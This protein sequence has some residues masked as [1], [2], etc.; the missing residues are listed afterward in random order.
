[1]IGAGAFGTVYSAT[2]ESGTEG[3]QKSALKFLPTGTCTP[4]QLGH[5]RDLAEREVALLKRVRA[6]RL[7][8]MHATMT[9]DDPER[10]ELDGA[11]VLVLERAEESLEA[12][13]ERG[14]LGREGAALL[15]QIC[16]GLQQLHQEGWV[17]GD[18]KPA[19]VLLMEDRSV[20]LADFNMA[21]ELDGTHAYAPAFSTSDY[22]APELLWS[23]VSDRGR[24][25]RPAADIWAFGVIA[26][27]VLT[28][29]LPW[30]GG[31]PS[32]RRD[33]VARY[34][35]GR[36][37]LR[38]AAG[39]SADWRELIADCLAPTDEARAAHNAHALL[40]RLRGMLQYVPAQR[41]TAAPRQRLTHRS[42]LVVTA[43]AALTG[44]GAALYSV[45]W[46]GTP[47]ASGMQPTVSSTPVT[48][49]GYDR[50]LPGNVC[51]FTEPDGQGRMCAW[52]GDEVDWLAGAARCSWADKQPSR[53]V[54]NNGND[55]TAGEKF[56]DVIYFNERHLKDR[57]GCVPVKTRTN[58]GAATAP[59]SHVWTERC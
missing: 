58:I 43:L 27:L 53:S 48:P 37:E 1:M 16:E 41:S 26:H 56:V 36:E 46:E 55:T 40:T 13:L 20:R 21:S 25:I 19:N 10:P 8:R 5:L 45:R 30:P 49:L 22:T 50:C 15:V 4:R 18:L 6:P 39:L 29:S 32:V 31:T 47:T 38:L 9:V 34:A 24:R 57:M 2:R 12:L 3:G 52:A 14:P 35:R 44:L 51:F 42:M 28:G 11:T 17:H 54:F 59:R 33:V 23:E 7:I